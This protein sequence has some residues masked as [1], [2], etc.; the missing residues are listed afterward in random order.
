LEHYGELVVAYVREHHEWAAPIA[1]VLS[2]LESIAFFSFFIPAWAALIGIGALVGASGLPLL[3]VWLAAAIGAA[4]GDWVSY[5]IGYKFKEPI[6]RVWPLSRHPDLVLHGQAFVRKWGVLAI[7]IG[8]FF[9][10]MRASVPLIAGI[11]QMPYLTF[12]IVNFISAFVWAWAL[13]VFGDVVS[14]ALAGLA[15]FTSLQE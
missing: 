9:G 3:P 14:S 5:W 13:L 11:L 15:N 12:Q 10:P 4:L 1:F 6:T 7:F 8:R 2:F